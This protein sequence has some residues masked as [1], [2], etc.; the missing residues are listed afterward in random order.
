MD[1]CIRKAEGE[2]DLS[3][4]L[5]LGRRLAAVI[6]TGLHEPAE[7]QAFQDAFSA[8]NLRNPAAGSLSLIAEDSVG[9]GHG[10]LHALPGADG[11]TGRTIGYVAL[12]AVTEE[13]EGTGVAKR[14]LASAED[15]AREQG[16]AALSLD[17]F[18]S[19]HRG[20]LFY[21]RNGFATETLRLVKKL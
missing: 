4:M 14:L 7:I 8:V 2:K 13:A 6:E 3:F 1:I 16:Y 19:N 18:A 11:I 15:W 17:V 20:R 9:I 5:G 21:E 10:F 12:L